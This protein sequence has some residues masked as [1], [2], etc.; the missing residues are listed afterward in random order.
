MLENASEVTLLIPKNIFLLKI[1]NFVQ[2]SMEYKVSLADGISSS[3]LRP[4][5]V[6]V[7]PHAQEHGV[8]EHPNWNRRQTHPDPRPLLPASLDVL[9]FRPRPRPR[10]P[11][12]RPRPAEAAQPES[13]AST[14]A[15]VAVMMAT[16]RPDEHAYDVM[17]ATAP[18][19]RSRRRR[20]WW[21]W[22]P[23]TDLW[24]KHWPVEITTELAPAPLRTTVLHQNSSSSSLIPFSFIASNLS[25]K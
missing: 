17:G 13:E 19:Q 10:R 14:A 7:A 24:R 4:Q 25:C 18:P 8:D 9:C 12:Q 5:D 20:R 2:S 21:H 1:L 16:S 15:A 22:R 23:V 6:N 3:H 11:E